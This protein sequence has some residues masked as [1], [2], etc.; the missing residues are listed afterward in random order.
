MP[1]QFTRHAVERYIQF[2]LMDDQADERDVKAMLE[3]ESAAAYRLPDKTVRGD[4][5]W[6][7]DSLGCDMV[8]RLEEGGVGVDVVVTI[9]PPP[10]LRGYTPQQA[11]RIT[12][13]VKRLDMCKKV[14]AEERERLAREQAVATK[15]GATDQ[16]RAKANQ[17]NARLTELRE[18]L[19][20]V[21][22]EREIMTDVLRAMRT[23]FRA[24][25]R[26]AMEM[27]RKSAMAL[28]VLLKMATT[29]PAPLWDEM[30]RAV[31][32]IGPHFLG[33]WF[34]SGGGE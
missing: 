15:K 8:T 18:T 27:K 16:E 23:K 25:E 7:I 31:I 1:F 28:R 32:E 34:M 10:E 4:I 9:L 3:I 14:A 2:Y 5:Q 6:R 22:L 30:R 24:D 33:D 12:E 17:N 13:Y 11:E 19:T 29:A 20:I 21:H 26:M